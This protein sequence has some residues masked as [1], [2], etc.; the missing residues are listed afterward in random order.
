MIWYNAVPP[1]GT[2][3]V[4]RSQQVDL[5]YTHPTTTGWAGGAFVPYVNGSR[6]GYVLNT[7]W[8]TEADAREFQ[9]AYV[10]LLRSRNAT[11]E[12]KGTYRISGSDPYANAFRVTRRGQP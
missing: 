5:T 7:V 10:R 11:V 12:R 8:E 2:V 4:T 3:K 6:H 9:T 1:N